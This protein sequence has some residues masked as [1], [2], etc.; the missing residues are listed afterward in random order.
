MNN[1][2]RI[3]VQFGKWF[4]EQLSYF[5]T[6]A[7]PCTMIQHNGI[8]QTFPNGHQLN[9]C[10]DEKNEYVDLVNKIKAGLVKAL[11]AFKK[12]MNIWTHLLL[13]VCSLG[14]NHD[15]AFTQAVICAVLNS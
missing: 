7:D 11:D 5:L 8:S 10:L 12:W 13:S 4:Y 2:I 15:Q 14:G 3:M 9:E 6:T 1:L